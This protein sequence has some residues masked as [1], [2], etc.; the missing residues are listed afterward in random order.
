MQTNNR[1]LDDIAKVANGAM[2][3][4]SGLREEIEQLVRH[5]FE[6]FINER[7]LVTREEFEAARAMALKAREEN[8]RLAERIAELEVVIKKANRVGPSRKTA[9]GRAKSAKPKAPKA[10]S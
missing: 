5:Q 1:I 10:D 8:E 6:R 7:G 3:A 4:F 9:T 2:S